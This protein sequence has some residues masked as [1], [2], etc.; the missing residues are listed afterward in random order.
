VNVDVEIDIADAGLLRAVRAALM[1]AASAR[2]SV[3]DVC[4]FQTSPLRQPA[5]AFA[6]ELSGQYGFLAVLVGADDMRTQFAR[7]AVV[8]ADHLPFGKDRIA[9][10]SVGGAGHWARCR[11]ISPQLGL[12]RICGRTLQPRQY[13]RGAGPIEPRRA[14]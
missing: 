10:E 3:S 1:P 2:T 8:G 13:R 11:A 9:E 12:T 6:G 5:A 7:E 4:H 14:C